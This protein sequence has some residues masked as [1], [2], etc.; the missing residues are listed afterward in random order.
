MGEKRGKGS[1][2]EPLGISEHA[3][4]RWQTMA[5]LPD[6]RF[7]QLIGTAART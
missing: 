1:T 2:L 3:S 4:H 5:R 7:F 6:E